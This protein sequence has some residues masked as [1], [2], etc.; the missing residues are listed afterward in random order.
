MKKILILTF[1]LILLTNRVYGQMSKEATVDCQINKTVCVQ[2]IGYD[3]IKVTFDIIPKPVE[4]MKELTYKITLTKN[5]KPITDAKITMD[6][7]MPG[8]F[9]G[10]NRPVIKHIG[11]G[12]YEGKGIIPRCPSGRKIWRANIKIER[13]DTSSI[14]SF[15]FEGK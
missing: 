14:V 4:F 8:M 5:D 10:T 13:N 6:L 3:K 1:L 15:T 2:E 11:T 12:V 7:T 9:M